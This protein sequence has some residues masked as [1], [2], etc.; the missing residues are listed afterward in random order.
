MRNKG[1][2]SENKQGKQAQKESRQ[3]QP[4]RKEPQQILED[5]P[6]KKTPDVNRLV[7][8]ILLKYNDY[9]LTDQD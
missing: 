3:N 6:L 7:D 2:G 9:G 8:E 5:M 1:K 4:V